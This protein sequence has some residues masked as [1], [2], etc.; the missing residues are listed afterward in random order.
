V[1]SVP[2]PAIQPV[3][4]TTR[5]Q[6][7]VQ[8][9]QVLPTPAPVPVPVQTPAP[10]SA[11]TSVRAVL[12]PLPTFVGR[13]WL[14]QVDAT[15]LDQNGKV[16]EGL[17]ANDFALTE[18][19]KPQ[20]I[21]VFEFQKVQQLYQAP[22]P[23]GLNLSITSYYVLGY[24]TTNGKA[25]GAYRKIGIVLKGNSTARLDFRAG[26]YAEKGFSDYI[27][28]KVG[29]HFTVDGVTDID[30]GS[31]TTPPAVILKVDPEYSE[32]ARKAKYSGDV[33]LLAEVGA[34]GQVTSVTVLN[35]LGMGLDEKA[36]EALT[37]W[38]F[39]P[40]TKDGNPVATPVRVDVTFRLL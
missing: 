16:V 5:R 32:Q 14:V 18:D 34:S 24:Y 2:Q 38:K 35:S 20:A 8:M 15:V 28:A 27:D 31:K 19:G 11:G 12:S 26:Y 10:Q 21:G 7:R 30:T 17:S 29:A 33:G 1:A 23:G 39:R 4:T 13:T 9:S 25:D 40:G 3:Q 6:T 37:K 22:A 36:V